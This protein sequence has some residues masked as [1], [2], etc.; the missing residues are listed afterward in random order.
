M[1]KRISIGCLLGFIFSLLGWIAIP[2]M[3]VLVEGPHAVIPARQSYL[4]DIGIALVEIVA[5]ILSIVGVVTA[6]RKR[7]KLRGLGI[8]GIAI[9]AALFFIF[10]SVLLL[11]SL[12]FHESPPTGTTV[13]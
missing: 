12:G 3:Q 4:I 11:I 1:K 9:S 10:G 8:A 5:L 13:S 2:V 7:L 6:S